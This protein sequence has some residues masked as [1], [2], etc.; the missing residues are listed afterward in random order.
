MDETNEDEDTRRLRRELRRLGQVPVPAGLLRRLLAIP[1]DRK[2]A[3]RWLLVPAVPAAVAAVAIVLV[4]RQP[5]PE[6]DPGVATLQE[7]RV[8]MS[9]I[10]RG[11][12]VTNEEISNAIQ[13][14]LREA[15]GI[16]RV[17]VLGEDRRA[18]Q[19]DQD[20]I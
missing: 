12:T 3:W 4:A 17:S 13:T 2:P 18:Q 15:Y 10:R 19:G 5:L 9:Y 11:A 8:A 14:G 1:S 6:E 20:E 16:S 7:F